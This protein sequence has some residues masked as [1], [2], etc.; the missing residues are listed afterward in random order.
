MAEIP[1]GKCDDDHDRG[2]LSVSYRPEN[3]YSRQLY[4]HLIA[5]VFLVVI[6]VF[7][8]LSVVGLAPGANAHTVAHTNP[9]E[10]SISAAAS[11]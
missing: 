11:S 1:A 10:R 8:W 2:Q 7:A 6:T 5:T 3:P 4:R 9:S